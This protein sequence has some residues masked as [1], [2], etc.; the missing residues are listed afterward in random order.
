MGR[1]WFIFLWSHLD[2]WSSGSDAKST[3]LRTLIVKYV[4]VIKPIDLWLGS[5]LTPWL[6]HEILIQCLSVN[7]KN[8]QLREEN[9]EPGWELLLSPVTENGS[10]RSHLP[11]YQMHQG[12]SQW[13]S[14]LHDYNGKIYT[15]SIISLF[16]A[17]NVRLFS[18]AVQNQLSK[19]HFKNR[20]KSSVVED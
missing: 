15:D 8:H 6:L 1:V 13:M 18:K 9:D 19:F 20:W 3:T 16:H 17:K 10:V 12:I 5:F 2:W 14:H 7:S 11:L 4:P